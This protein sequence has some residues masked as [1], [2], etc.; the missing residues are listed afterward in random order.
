MMKKLFLSLIL[1]NSALSTTVHAHGRLEVICGPMFAG[2]SEELIRRL[3]RAV[4]GKLKVLVVKPGIDNRDA[5]N[6][7]A[8]HNGAVFAAQTISAP[9]DLLHLADGYEVIGIDEVQ[10][11]PHDI[12]TVIRT[13]VAQGKRV[14][15]SGLD[16]DYRS[17]PFGPIAA[18]LSLADTVT[19]LQAICT[20]CGAD[21]QRSQRIINGQP[22]RYSDPLIMI[23]A[24][25]SYQAR[26]KQ[27]YSIES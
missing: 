16:L 1:I 21:A 2:K 13:L 18:L 7:I 24:E 10:F 27:C 3:T 23:G 4:I 20:Q 9:A 22:A 17:E 19:K 14:I 26:C 25:E 15:V 8:S 11:F 5:Q 12:I 6:I